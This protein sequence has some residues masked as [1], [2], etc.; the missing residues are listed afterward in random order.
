MG[1]M[2]GL[3]QPTVIVDLS[4]IQANVQAIA[5]R[6]GVPVIAVVK[7]DAYGLGARHVVEAIGELV[8]AFY[9]F[10]AVEALQY[11]DLDTDKLTIAML[12]RSDDPAD[13][14]SRRIRPAVWTPQRAEAMRKARPVLSV[15]TGQQRFGCPADRV[16]SVLRTGACDEALS[17]A[18][19]VAQARLLRDAV[20]GRV[21]K[22]HAAGSGLL[23]EPDAWLDAVRPGLALY[24]DAVRVTVPLLDARDATGPAGYS[25][26]ISSTG[27]L[28]LIAVGYSNGMRARGSCLMNGE[29]RRIPEIGMQSAFVEVGPRDK[30]GD[31]VVLLGNGITPQSI[32]A[33]W[34]TSPQEALLKLTG[35][36]SRSYIV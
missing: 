32:A 36:G 3:E 25:G 10:D 31:Q 35:I 30:V 24:H 13:Y 9:V 14:I 23:A 27:R 33:A 21:A 12:G 28:G 11:A 22:M 7:A 17:H 16:E 18:V 29:L 19:T 8:E 6:T 5:H 2:R 1:L 20:G 15:D 26:F 34:G 4:R